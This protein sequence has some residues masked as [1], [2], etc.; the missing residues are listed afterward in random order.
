[1]RGV[2]F[3]KSVYPSLMS[4]ILISSWL[5]PFNAQAAINPKLEDALESAARELEAEEKGLEWRSEAQVGLLDS[6]GKTETRTLSG[7]LRLQVES[8]LWRNDFRA[9]FRHTQ[10]DGSTSQESMNLSHQADYQ[11]TKQFYSL[12]FAGYGHDRFNTFRHEYDLVTGVGYR[13]Y[14]QKNR[15]WDLEAGLGVKHTQ[16]NDPPQDKD[17][18]PLGRLASKLRLDLRDDLEFQQEIAFNRSQEVESLNIINGLAVKANEHL[19]VSLSYEW[20]R[21]EDLDASEAVYDH[22]TT[23]NLIYRWHP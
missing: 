18:S 21:S 4:L 17:W 14:R 6:R 23:L 9:N 10:T 13:L 7:R 8:H 3:V 22:I 19:A 1:M 15:E 20:Q 11:W 2:A 5:I 12:V 16:R